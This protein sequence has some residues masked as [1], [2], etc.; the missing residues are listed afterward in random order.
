MRSCGS[1]DNFECG[2]GRVPIYCLPLDGD[3]V[4]QDFIQIYAAL[5]PTER[6]INSENV[7]E[8]RQSITF[9][10][11]HPFPNFH[12]PSP[13]VLPCGRQP[14]TITL[15]L[16]NGPVSTLTDAIFHLEMRCGYLTFQSSY[17]RKYNF[18]FRTEAFYCPVAEE[19]HIQSVIHYQG[20]RIAQPAVRSHSIT[21][22]GEYFCNVPI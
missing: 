5:H 6:V 8:V 2:C 15:C 9:V 16:G 21:L 17:N 10:L 11:H 3:W 22:S 4:M 14:K 20:S 1:D 13:S 18:A 12:F 7:L 19:S